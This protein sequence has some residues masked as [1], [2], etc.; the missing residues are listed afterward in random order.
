MEIFWK[1]SGNGPSERD[2]SRIWVPP[3][4]SSIPASVTMKDGMPT[5]A[6]QNPCQAPATAPMTSATARAST[7][8]TWCSTIITAHAAETKA[9]SEP[10]DRSM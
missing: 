10:T 6:I 1:P 5:Y 8:G 3:R 7:Q 4:K 9:A 2:P